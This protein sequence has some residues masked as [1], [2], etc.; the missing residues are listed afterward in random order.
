MTNNDFICFVGGDERQRYAVNHLAEYININAV[1]EVFC[2]VKHSRV[3]YFE[4]PNKAI[5]GASAII[6][7]VPASTSESVV[8][9]SDIA[10]IISKAPKKVYVLGGK[11]SPYLKGLIEKY[12]I[13]YDDYYDNECFTLKNAYLTAE[14]A[15]QLAMT[16]LKGA[17]RFSKC[18]ILG[19]GRIGKALGN[20]L[21]S[22]HAD[23]TVF[24]RKEEDLALATENGLKTQNIS[25]ISNALTEDFDIIFNTVPERILHNEALLSLPSRTVLIELASA[26]GGLDPDIAAQCDVQFI[27]G[28]GIPGKYAPE[29][30]G[31]IASD[32]IFQYLKKEGI[33]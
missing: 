6:L 20:M 19:Y 25:S 30:A 21:K 3:S 7:P 27:N 24:A 10:E 2:S 22:L 13:K 17:I 18:A 15:V 12:D 31:K 5:Y 28:R 26:P 32:T 8:A 23:V 16:A 4:N 29:T 9:F 33:L 11:F 1:G 14:G